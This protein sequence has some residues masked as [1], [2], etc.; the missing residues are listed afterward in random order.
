MDRIGNYKIKPF[1]KSRRNISLLLEEGARMH[2][3]H[4]LIELDVTKA[5]E[6]IR[7]YKERTG[8][9]ISFTG[10]IVKCV[11]QAIS[12]HKELNAYRIGRKK[13]A[14]FDDVDVPIPIERYADRELRPMAYVIRK[15]NEKSVKEITSEIRAV[16]KEVVDE[17]TQILGGDLLWTER[18]VLSA[19]VF[20][21]K[22]IAWIVRRN[23]L[24]RK[25]YMGTVGVTAIGMMGTFPGWA[26]P[27]GTPTILIVLGGITKKPV[28]IEG[29]IEIHEH[30]YTT[31][32]VDHDIIDGGPLVRF[33][34]RLGELT[35][36]AF[37]LI[38]L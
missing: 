22:L 10:W 1:P 29:K 33:I 2:S 37:G 20:I 24:L 19:P 11:G 7:N 8:E 23:G 35:K 14:F 27:L 15:V 6:I 36:N 12:E 16:Q 31:V 34:T 3:I 32:T 38:D 9:H 18:F 5:R 25:K 13:I 30:L 28:V 26:I 17:S 4:A 21:Q